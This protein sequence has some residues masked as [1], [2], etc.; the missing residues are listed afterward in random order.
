[1]NWM[2]SADFEAMVREHFGL[3]AGEH[4]SRLQTKVPELTEFA[5]K[6]YELGVADG[7]YDARHTRT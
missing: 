6:V 7:R 1:M 4:T 2:T 3:P 5:R